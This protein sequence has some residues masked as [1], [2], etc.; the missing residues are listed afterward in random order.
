M[1]KALVSMGIASFLFGLFGVSWEKVDERIAREFPRVAHISTEEFHS[2]L[3]AGPSP[4]ALVIDVRE[5]EEF[6]VSHI[7]GA[8]N[9]A[10]SEDIAS[11]VAD[12]DTEILVY[13]S[14]GYR[15]AGVASRLAELGY[16]NV[17]N[18]H[19]SIF[20]WANRGYPLRN[21]LGQTDKVHPFNRAWG[22]LLNEELHGE[23]D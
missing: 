14:V 7:E 2:R 13:C 9:I 23:P 11:R 4:G 17:K 10:R 5:A 3:Q 6:A 19:H 18:L 1:L 8:I 22:S 20:E 16:T 21:E 15:S 12:K